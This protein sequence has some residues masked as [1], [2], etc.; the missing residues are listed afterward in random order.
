VLHI[1][2]GHTLDGRVDL[3]AGA[4]GRAR[5]LVPFEPKVLILQRALIF[6]AGASLY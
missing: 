1:R 2:G 3:L 6:A 4:A 5:E